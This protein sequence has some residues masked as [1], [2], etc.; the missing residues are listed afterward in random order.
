M[1]GSVLRLESAIYQ[2]P[3]NDLPGLCELH[4]NENLF[5]STV[6]AEEYLVDGC[7]AALLG[8]LNRYPAQGADRLKIE[9]ARYASCAPVHVVVG[10][11]SSELLRLLFISLLSRGERVLLPEPSWNFYRLCAQLV[12]ATVLSYPLLKREGGYDYDLSMMKCRIH[13]YDPKVVVVC[14]PNNPTGNSI[15]A[16]DLLELVDAHRNVSFIVDQA[17]CGFVEDG[18]GSM[19]ILQRAAHRPNLFVTRTF[20]KFMGLADIR[21]G[22]LVCNARRALAMSAMAP[23]LGIPTLNQNLA[24]SRLNDSRL[25]NMIRKE[26][27]EVREYVFEELRS[28]EGVDPCWTDANFIFMRISEGTRDVCSELRSHGFIVKQEAIEA[29]GTYL[30]VTIADHCTMRGLL[31]ALRASVEV[32][33]EMHG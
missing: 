22:Y 27:D 6:A 29:A 19:R 24:I 8:R 17:Y 30:R 11:G 18:G 25:H 32:R 5:A 15:G 4:L 26:F 10:N 14:S 23:V 2:M 21:V 1:K 31:K 9:L 13:S 20:S 7:P 33:N 3:E 16:D 28:V 12:G